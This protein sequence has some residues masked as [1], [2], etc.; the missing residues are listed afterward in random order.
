MSRFREKLASGKFLVTA[1]LVYPGGPDTGPLLKAVMTLRTRVDAFHI[2]WDGEPLMAI[3]PLSLAHHLMGKGVEPI[4]QF[5]SN[6]RGPVELQKE[7]L[8]TFVMGVKNLLFVDGGEGSRVSVD[9]L[10]L[11]EGA[12]G[13]NLL[14]THGP[15]RRAIDPLCVGVT[16][17]SEAADLENEVR[18]MERMAQEGASFFQARPTFDPGAFD[19]FISRVENIGAPVFA[20]IVPL[21]S[22]SMARRF[23]E[24][25][26]S[27][28][29]PEEIIRELE[30][31]RDPGRAGIEIAAR[32]L[33]ELKEI[34]VGVRVMAAGWEDNITKV[35]AES[36]LTPPR[37]WS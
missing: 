34:C 15:R 21:R 17:D 13:L 11:V 32:L 33:R 28:H 25:M 26:P 19:R 18:R 8:N 31:S 7:L 20:S 27:V 36:G 22:A 10:T 37:R 14:M 6:A 29:L 23:R 16:V 24:L 4:L 5:T 35:L 1:D 2:T 30:E 12:T 9:A 3:A